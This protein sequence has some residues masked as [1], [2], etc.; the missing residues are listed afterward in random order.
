[1]RRVYYVYILRCE[2]NCLYTGITSDVER[3][4]RE[5]CEGKGAKYTKTHPP[6]GVEAVWEAV[7]KNDASRLEYRIK[8]LTKEE[9]EDLILNGEKELVLKVGEE[10]LSFKRLL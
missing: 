5:H 9:K 8:A 3:R 1:V 4:F 6:L 2:K 7:N 10:K